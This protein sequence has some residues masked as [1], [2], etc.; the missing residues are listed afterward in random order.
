MSDLLGVDI[1]PSPDCSKVT[2]RQTGYIDRLVAKWFPDGAPALTRSNKVPAGPDLAQLVADALA[3]T[4]VP[5]S[6]AVRDFQSIVGALLYAATNTRPDICYAVGMLCRAMSRPTPELQRSALQVL[7]YLHRTRL[8]GLCYERSTDPVSGAS[9]SDWGIQRST[10]G[11]VF[12][13]QRA[14]VSWASTKQTSV[15]LSSCEAE[16]MALSEA[17]K[18]ALHLRGLAQEL[19][20]G[21]D[22]PTKLG[23]DNTAARDLS[24]NPEY[25]KRVKHIER[26]H[27]F[28]RECVENMQISVPY[29][30][31]VDNL[32]DFFTKVQDAKTFVAMR[33]AIMNVSLPEAPDRGSVHEGA[34]KVTGD[35]SVRAP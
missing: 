26:R 8:L 10:S 15:A 7:E 24:Y 21:D 22:A 2:L 31:T 1:T 19:G 4:E 3:S 16:I 18:E 29:V 25:H 30:N 23:C 35:S 28:V 6:S 27:F 5:C 20:V 33:D 14:S 32:A 17:A 11:S 12:L 9:D 13:F 34:L